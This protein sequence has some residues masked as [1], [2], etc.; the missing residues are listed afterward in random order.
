MWDVSCKRT[1]TLLLSWDV[2]C[3][4]SK[5]ENQV[6]NLRKSNIKLRKVM[7][8]KH[9]SE[10]GKSPWRKTIYDLAVQWKMWSQTRYPESQLEGSDCSQSFPFP[11]LKY[12]CWSTVNNILW[13]GA[14]YRAEIQKQKPDQAFVIFNSNWRKNNDRNFS[15]I[16]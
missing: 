11:P 12:F 10:R 13:A 2:R 5:D 3:G 9:L 8:K 4:L 16:S 14:L 15:S 6:V 1:R 7:I